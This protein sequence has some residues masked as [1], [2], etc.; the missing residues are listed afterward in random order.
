MSSD[1]IT[2][3]LI[4]P[5]SQSDID[6]AYDE[7]LHNL[8]TRPTAIPRQQ[9]LMEKQS[10]VMDYYRNVRTNVLLA[11]ALSNVRL[12]ALLSLSSSIFR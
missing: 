10:E 2:I 4:L 6:S 1:G 3:E 11:W 5:S 12:S 9:T 7:A 8:K